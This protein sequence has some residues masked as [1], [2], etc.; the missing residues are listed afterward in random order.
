MPLVEADEDGE[1]PRA[2]VMSARRVREDLDELSA[3]AV[4]LVEGTLSYEDAL[5]GYFPRLL[6]AFGGD[7]SMV[8]AFEDA[9]VGFV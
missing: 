4:M 3:A 7:R 8:G 5:A 2:R 9:H 1:G 6:D